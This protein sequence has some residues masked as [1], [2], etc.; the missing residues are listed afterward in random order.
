MNSNSDLLDVFEPATSSTSTSRRS[1]TAVRPRNRRLISVDDDDEDSGAQ[2]LGSRLSA[3]FSGLT[4]PQ[5]RGTSPSPSVSRRGSPLPTKYPSRTTETDVGSRYRSDDEYTT[6]RNGYKASSAS[7]SASALLESSWSSLQSLASSVLGSES[8]SKTSK[9]SS[10]T[11]RKPS[12]S[13]F[14]IS[15]PK[16]TGPSSWGP[17]ASSSVQIGSGTKEERQALV[18]AKKRE[19]LLLANGDSVSSL[20]GRYKRRDSTERPGPATIDPEHDEEALVYVHNVQPNDTMTGIAI[21]YGCLP[22]VFRKANGF[23]PSDSVQ[24]RKTVL[25]PTEACSVK[26]RRVL[27]DQE[28]D[29]LADESFRKSPIEDFNGSSIVP[30]ETKGDLATTAEEG[31][32]AWK[33]EA[34]VQIEGFPCNVEIG[35][36]PRGTL[37]FFPRS[38]R[39][40]QVLPY[41]DAESSTPISDL[42]TIPQR[43]NTHSFDRYETSPSPS[44]SPSWMTS[45]PRSPGP[46]PHRSHRRTGSNYFLAG[47][48]GVGTLGRE[49]TAPGP[50]PDGLNKFFAQHLPNLTA[51]PPPPSLRKASFD[52]TSTVLSASSTTGLENVGGAIEGWMRKMASRAKTGLNELQSGMQTPQGQAVGIGGMGDLIE[53]N[54]GLEGTTPPLNSVGRRDHLGGMVPANSQYERYSNPST[55]TSRARSFHP[56]SDGERLKGD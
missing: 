17:S 36:V 12:R 14:P 48:G 29:L 51:P 45:E 4:P 6:G 41:T 39:K 33:H 46:R 18:Q 52:S 34:W 16:Q 13:H 10:H 31:E 44:N 5:S 37:G 30:V 3:A 35:R 1:T 49:A 28:Q 42:P 40:S 25:L 55:S 53:L 26:G 19:T 11:R 15:A 20:K 56:N 23:W 9:P 38:R 24:A 50:A 8:T 54:D 32:R 7:Q 2:T 47:P 21:R 27:S 43:T 22:A